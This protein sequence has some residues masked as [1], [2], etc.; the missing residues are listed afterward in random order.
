MFL[1]S[2][3][4]ADFLSLYFFWNYH[5]PNKDTY[6]FETGAKN[7]ALLIDYAKETGLYVVAR[8]GPYINAESSAGGLALWG[9]DG[10]AGNL[11]TS[12]ITYYKYWVPW[13]QKIGAIIAD[14]Q[15]TNGGV[16]PTKDFL[17]FIA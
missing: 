8:P 3:E 17:D 2:G 9:A 13:M 7:I 10:S 11:R 1:G 12:D 5:S 4:L 15:I 14:N 6:D 16:R